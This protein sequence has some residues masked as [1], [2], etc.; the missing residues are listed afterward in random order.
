MLPQ[1]RVNKQDTTSGGGQVRPGSTVLISITA[2]EY[3][4]IIFKCPPAA[5]KYVDEDDGEIVRVGSSL[6]LT[7]RLDDPVPPLPSTKRPANGW[8]R[9]L[10]EQHRHHLFD[11]N[12]RK[13]VLG[14]W[15]YL[16][17]RTALPPLSPKSPTPPVASIMAYN[18]PIDLMSDLTLSYHDITNRPS[19]YFR[20]TNPP[21]LE[22]GQEP[23]PPLSHASVKYSAGAL[24]TADLS[25]TRLTAEGRRQASKPPK[26]PSLPSSSATHLEY[27]EPQ[28]QAAGMEL[29]AEPS[30][31]QRPPKTVTK[32][33]SNSDQ[34]RWASRGKSSHPFGH[35]TSILTSRNVESSKL[36]KEVILRTSMDMCSPLTQTRRALALGVSAPAEIS[37]GIQVDAR[38]SQ[39]DKDLKRHDP[40][41]ISG[42][43]GREVD[44]TQFPKILETSE[45]VA[46]PSLSWVFDDELSKLSKLSN[47]R[48]SKLFAK[49]S[50][51]GNK[52]VSPPE[53][54]SAYGSLP[55]SE[56][57]ANNVVD[58]PDNMFQSFIDRAG[59]VNFRLQSLD[60]EVDKRV[61]HILQTLRHGIDTALDDFCTC[62]ESVTNHLQQTSNPLDSVC[63][64]QGKT[65]RVKSQPGEKGLE[66]LGRYPPP[67]SNP[68]VEA[69]HD[70]T[71][72]SSL[73]A[74][75]DLRQQDKNS[76]AWRP[77][78]LDSPD[79][80]S[81]VRD[82]TKCQS[83]SNVSV[84]T[85]SR[86]PSL[87]RFE[88]EHFQESKVPRPAALQT[89]T[90]ST[91]CNHTSS[92]QNHGL[93]ND[94]TFD[95]SLP[96]AIPNVMDW[97]FNAC[98][99]RDP[100]SR[101][102]PSIFPRQVDLVAPTAPVARRPDFQFPY[103]GH[104]RDGGRPSQNLV[105]PT[106]YHT[107]VTDT[108]P[109]QTQITPSS[110]G[111]SL[112]SSRT[113]SGIF[114]DASTT[115]H[116]DPATAASIQE[117]VDELQQ[118]GFGSGD[119]GVSRLVVYAQA[120]GGD[121]VEAMDLI[122]EEERV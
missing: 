1:F 111:T 15:H 121:L 106:A 31:A 86:F 92:K 51:Q 97:P 50:C 32:A 5:L 59:A 62:I 122:A 87:E 77:S 75:A 40:V 46:R 67:S 72:K 89:L 7:Q 61:L 95:A 44:Q 9:E 53:P 120:A 20:K 103:D 98:Q 110:D 38:K 18:V 2:S 10:A 64:N 30:A 113:G 81:A 116:T 68:S 93:E 82:A 84:S 80:S 39:P 71:E 48:F 109:L 101:Q 8:T 22:S 88:Q 49:D 45:H 105:T 115:E 43:H 94:I 12:C 36:G 79:P 108:L 119:R 99:R 17:Q 117:C 3:D 74:P 28:A 26:L 118:M 16:A 52:S 73:K 85:A 56:M 96:G 33:G 25:S 90:S 104:L 65:D 76:V 34:T 114:D 29:R 58:H 107:A 6:E 60:H 23:A 63:L 55:I 66:A 47:D 112:G 11:I 21:S 78:C 69:P 54:K 4:D 37:S 100:I 35:P 13:R 70:Y 24:G 19:Q 27:K 41:A 91:Y 83:D 14:I 57:P 42:Y 102:A